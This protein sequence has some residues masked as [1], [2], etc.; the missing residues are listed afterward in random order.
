MAL[1]ACGVHAVDLVAT[2]AHLP[3]MR[4]DDL[5][6]ELR[7]HGATAAQ[8]ELGGDVRVAGTGWDGGPWRVRVADPTGSASSPLDVVLPAGGGVATS[9]V[10]SRAWRRGGRALH[11]LVD[12]STA[13]PAQTDLASVTVAAAK[14]FRPV[15]I[16]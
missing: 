7:G 12:P 10:T 1:Y 13:W 9:G 4:P 3:G 5:C 11:H 14:G 6:S 15:S 8:V 2:S 16:S